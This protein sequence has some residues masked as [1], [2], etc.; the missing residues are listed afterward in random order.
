[1]SDEVVRLWSEISAL[2]TQLLR[3]WPA[4]SRQVIGVALW[5][6]QRRGTIEV[7]RAWP[8]GQS[9]FVDHGN[10]VSFSEKISLMPS[11]FVTSG[12]PRSPTVDIHVSGPYERILFSPMPTAAEAATG[13]GGRMAQPEHLA[14]LRARLQGDLSRGSIEPR[15]KDFSG[16]SSVPI[17]A[18]DWKRLTALSAERTELRKTLQVLRHP[19]SNR[20]SDEKR[21]ARSLERIGE[22]EVLIEQLQGYPASIDASPLPSP[23]NDFTYFG[24]TPMRIA[25]DDES[26]IAASIERA[27]ARLPRRR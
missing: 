13:P 12:V 15:D 19:L 16:W 22:V 25:E 18:P 26:E 5:P 14:K 7:G 9:E 20:R 2:V 10:F 21:R 8:I 17:S 4:H 11:L 3:D 24:P 1:M 6:G 27:R 23:W